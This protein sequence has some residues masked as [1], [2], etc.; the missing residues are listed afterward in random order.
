MREET[1]KLVVAVPVL[2]EPS[3]LPSDDLQRSKQ[4]GGTMADV[5]V[6]ALLVVTRFHHTHLLDARSN[7]W[8]WDLT[9]TEHHRRSGPHTQP[10]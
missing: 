10:P 5:V 3:H 7:A 1:E 2:A 6:T 4:S 9:Q 8:T